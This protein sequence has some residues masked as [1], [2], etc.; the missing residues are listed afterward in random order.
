M[1]TYSPKSLGIKAPAGGF[2]TGGWYSGRQFWG[3]TLSEPGQIHPSSNQ[4]GA[5][6]A[7]SKEV[8]AQTSPANVPYIAQEQAK[9]LATPSSPDQVTPYLNAYQQDLLKTSQAPEVRIPL[10]AYQQDLLKTSQ[11]P[12]VRIPA[13]GELKTALAPTTPYPTPL[14]RVEELGRLQTEYGVSDLEARLK[15]LK[16][17]E[18]EAI[19]ALRIQTHTE[20]GKPVPLNVIAGRVSEATRQAQ[21]NLDFI[22]RQKSRV[23]DELNTKYNV[24][25]QIMTLQG[26]DYNDAV[27]RYET[28]FNISLK[29]YDLIAGARREARSAYEYD[30]TAARANLQIYANAAISGNVDYTS[31]GVDQ[32]LMISKLEIQSGLPIGFISSIKKDPKAN[33]IANW[34][35]EGQYHILTANPGGGSPVLQTFGTKSGTNGT[36]SG[37]KVKESAAIAAMQQKLIE[38]GG[39]DYLVS[40]KEWKDQRNIWQ[41]AGYDVSKF[42]AAFKRTFVDWSH[43]KDYGFLSLE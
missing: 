35:S 21:E 40:P 32:K 31:L 34:E 20:E 28:E 29:M 23:V 26:L 13:V 19:A 4:P 1:A 11:A 27:K 5:G 25:N 22:G 17:Q 16:A 41:Q 9:P 7:V 37:T 8:I 12:E 43:P 15:G 10:N 42:D 6:Q 14:K 39:E 36:K 18:D 24:I 30:Q 2:Q 3:G 33:I 38:L